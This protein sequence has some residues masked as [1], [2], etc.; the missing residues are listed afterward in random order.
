[1]PRKK[2]PKST[3]TDI[4]LAS[5]RRCALC[6]GLHGDQ[7]PKVG[8]IAH[9]DRN[10]S[11]SAFDNLTWLCLPHHDEYDARRS[12]SKGFTPEEL[13]RYRDALH[14]FV[15]DQREELEPSRPF[16]RFSAEGRALAELLNRS[17]KNGYKLDPQLRI[18]PLAGTL[19][20]SPETVELAIDELRTAGLAEVNG[21]NDVIHA[22]NRLFWE[23]DPIFA[24][25]DPV[26]DAE[27]V[28]RT[29]VGHASGTIRLSELATLLKW[30]PRRLNPAATYL[31][32]TNNA[33]GLATIGSAPFSYLEIERIPSTKRLVRNLQVRDSAG[34]EPSVERARLLDER[35]RI[36]T[37]DYLRTGSPR[38]MIDTFT[39]MTQQGK[40]DLYERAILW[41]KGRQ[42][43]DNPYR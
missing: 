26:S 27:L 24:T 13:R 21:S 32:E 40:A 29:L 10:A 7:N 33:R 39:D 23:T 17:S 14:S 11:N 22:T 9:I 15:A 34:S 25:S 20:V 3:E 28:A 1:M 30:D 2:T 37:A 5:R 18:D 36:V 19:A 6:F 16:V 4:L 8:Q 12:Q 42:P 31:V 43:K 35:F 41:K 38:T